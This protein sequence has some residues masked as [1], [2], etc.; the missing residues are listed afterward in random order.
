MGPLFW[1]DIIKSANGRPGYEAGIP[2]TIISSLFIPLAI[3][4][5]FQVFALQW[6]ILKIHKEGLWVR[7]IGTPFQI[8]PALKILPG[9]DF[10]LIILITL[11][12]LVTLQIFQTQ[13]IYWRW[14]DLDI[15]LPGNGNFLIV[16]WID[17][18]DSAQNDLKPHTVSYG[19]DSFGMSIN[20][21][22]ESVKFFHGNP[23][24]RGTLS[25]WRN[26]E[27]MIGY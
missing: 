21:V 17:T 2:L 3:Y 23:D 11:W 9:L 7:S 6:P 1:L 20:K 12:Q 15:M 22:R 8:D 4:F 25:C 26:D 16:G 27:T 5:S 13:V 19:A 14:E 10:I 24:L 18:D